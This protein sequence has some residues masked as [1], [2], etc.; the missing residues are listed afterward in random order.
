MHTCG[1]MVKMT[2]QQ[3]FH[4]GR[5]LHVHS[6]VNWILLACFPLHVVALILDV[7]LCSSNHCWMVTQRS[8]PFVFYIMLTKEAVSLCRCPEDHEM[9]AGGP[10]PYT[11]FFT[12][13][14]RKIIKQCKA[15][16]SCRPL[17][18]VPKSDKFV[19]KQFLQCSQLWIA[20]VL[21]QVAPS[22]K[23]HT[24]RMAPLRWSPISQGLNKFEKWI[25]FIF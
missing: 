1:V 24:L 8:E 19:R 11:S 15:K 9:K 3:V 6:E 12:L 14:Q 18:V 10:I 20:T 25:T 21:W 13:P 7:C 2:F 17:N 16:W 5:A 23:N 22:W 4:F